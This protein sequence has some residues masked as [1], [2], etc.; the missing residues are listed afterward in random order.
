MWKSEATRIFLPTQ[1][2]SLLLLPCN[3]LRAKH[4]TVHP[5]IS[6][7][8]CYLAV[9]D[10]QP[11]Q[12]I[13]RL[14]SRGPCPLRQ[15]LPGLA[16]WFWGGRKPNAPLRT[17]EPRLSWYWVA[18]CFCAVSKAYQTCNI[19]MKYNSSIIITGTYSTFPPPPAT[20][21]ALTVRL[22]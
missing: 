6:C 15:A 14:P 18:V 10:S 5:V 13:D 20:D 11:R 9:M 8:E 3:L 7:L 21:H 16:A 22:G 4:T 12:A 2:C 19:T 17:R 1:P